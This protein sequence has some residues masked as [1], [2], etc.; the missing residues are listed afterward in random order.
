MAKKVRVGIIGTGGIG[1]RQVQTLVKMKDVELVAGADVSDEAL[2]LFKKQFSVTKVFKDYNEMLGA[3]EMDAVTVC[4]PNS[5][6]KEP[7]I[8]ALKAGKD[9]MVEKPMAMSAAEAQ[10]MVDTAKK[11]G[12]KLVIGFQWRLMP[13]AQALKRCIKAGQLGNILFCRVQALR[14]RGIPN[15]GVFGRKELQGGGPL[16]DIGVHIMEMGHYLMGKPKAT[17]ACAG[18]YT[19]L[20]NKPSKALCAW[21][22]WDYK[23]YSVEDLAVGFIR[24]ENGA[25]M[26]VESSFAAHIEQDA[27]NVQLMGTE[28]GCTF[29][30]PRVFKDEAGLMVNVEPAYVG[31]WDS[32]DK[33]L[34]GWIAYVRG[35]AETECPGEDGL[36]V[37][38]MLDGLYASAEK[39]TEVKIS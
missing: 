8:A 27:F 5:L 13:N 7:T 9:V 36:S 23:T 30:P 38:K 17:S 37:Q 1:R 22:H 32:M 28:G 35:E 33:K 26:S 16:I 39:G 34:E 14:R 31:S 18:M 10:E 11:G 4:T 24:F 15:W 19:Y 6:H 25:C 2:D 20:G 29:N 12:R 3:V 21:D